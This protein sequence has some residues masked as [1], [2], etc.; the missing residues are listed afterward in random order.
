MNKS[1]RISFELERDDNPTLF[2][3]LARFPKGSRRVNRLRMLLHEGLLSEQARGRHGGAPPILGTNQ[4]PL[5]EPAASTATD[6]P[7]ASIELFGSTDE[8]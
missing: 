1:I 2:D 3:D 6:F 5:S 8:R 4:L 7:E